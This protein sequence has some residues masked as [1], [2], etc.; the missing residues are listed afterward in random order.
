MELRQDETVNLIGAERKGGGRG[1][2]DEDGLG[3]DSGRV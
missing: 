1:D 2:R 3:M